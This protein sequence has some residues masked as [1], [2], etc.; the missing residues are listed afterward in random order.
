MN[1]IE[2]LKVETRARCGAPIH[3]CIDEAIVLA[4]TEDRIVTLE[5]NERIFTIDP[6]AIRGIILKQAEL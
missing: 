6:A 2:V 5:H 1:N 4:F 3:A